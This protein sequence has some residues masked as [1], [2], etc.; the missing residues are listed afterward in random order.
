MIDGYS[1]K[2]SVLFGRIFSK[3][4]LVWVVLL[5]VLVC[6]ASALQN[7]GLGPNEE[8][9]CTIC[10]VPARTMLNASPGPTIVPRRHIYL[11]IEGPNFSEEN[12]RKAFE[13]LSKAYPQP[14]L[15]TIV[16]FSD[17][18]FLRQLISIEESDFVID[19]ADSAQGQEA[20]QQYYSKQYPPRKGYFRAY[21]LRS[22]I[23]Q[24]SFQYTPIPNDEKTIE[25]VLKRRPR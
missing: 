13:N 9:P 4:R 21:F 3:L 22:A 7:K 16:A 24:E 25:V 15:L 12:L 5:L 19:F 14:V 1:K 20:K 2:W 6:S 18:E 23:D 10:G 17:K 8:E 11:F